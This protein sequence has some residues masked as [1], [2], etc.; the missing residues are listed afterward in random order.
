M[1]K[2]VYFIWSPFLLS[3]VKN[4]IHNRTTTMYCTNKTTYEFSHKQKNNLAN[5]QQTNEI[6][7][8]YT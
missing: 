5:Q 2:F 3:Y 4:I 8:K 1:T 7:K 6:I